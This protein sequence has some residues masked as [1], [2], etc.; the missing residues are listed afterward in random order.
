MAEHWR[1]RAIGE[2]HAIQEQNVEVH[3]EVQRSR[4][5]GQQEP[6]RMRK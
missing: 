4:I 6:K 3:V 5:A 1:L 2:V